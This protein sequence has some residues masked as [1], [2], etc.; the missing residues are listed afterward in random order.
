MRSIFIF[1]LTFIPVISFGQI[2]E[3]KL[4]ENAVFQITKN[5]AVGYYTIIEAYDY[6]L[7]DTEA[8]NMKDYFL[9]KDGVFKFER[10]DEKRFKV[11]HFEE[12]SYEVITEMTA[13]F[14]ASY[15][16]HKPVLWRRTKQTTSDSLHE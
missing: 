1:A 8:S 14:I 6:E 13:N 16:V 3:E 4:F 12:I 2:N 5:E 11:Y 7:N 9:N 10:L 15:L